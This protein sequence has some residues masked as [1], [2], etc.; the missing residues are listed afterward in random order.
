MSKEKKPSKW[1]EQGL[2]GAGMVG[3]VSRV[4]RDGRKG[5]GEERTLSNK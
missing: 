4:N 1:V 2:D 5:S 3:G